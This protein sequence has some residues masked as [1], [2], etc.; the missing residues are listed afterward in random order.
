MKDQEGMILRNAKILCRIAL[1][2]E[3]STLD[4]LFDVMHSEGL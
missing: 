4:K 2:M 1:E 3:G